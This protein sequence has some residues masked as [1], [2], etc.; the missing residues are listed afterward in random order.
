VLIINA[1]NNLDYHSRVVEVDAGKI[2]KILGLSGIEV[3]GVGP[4]ELGSEIV[5]GKEKWREI[6]ARSP[7]DF[8]S[9]NVPGYL[10]Y[11]RLKKERGLRVL[12]T[13]VVDPAML[14]KAGVDYPVK[15]VDPEV[16][17][18]QVLRRVK[19]DLAIVIIQ[20]SQERIAEI[21]N[22]CSGIDLVVDGMSRGV[23]NNFSGNKKPAS[24]L[25]P[26]VYNNS[27]GK[28]VVCLDLELADSGRWLCEKPQRR[29]AFTDSVKPDPEIEVL[30]SELRNERKTRYA[31]LREEKARKYMRDNP[32]DMYLGARGCQN[33]HLEIWQQWQQTR[34]AGAWRSLVRKQREEDGACQSCHVT[35]MEVPNTVGG[36]MSPD[37][38][39]W[40]TGVQCEAC[41]GPGGR[42]VT[43]PEANRMLPGDEKG[44]LRCHD[45]QNDPNF[46]YREKWLKIKHGDPVGREGAKR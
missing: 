45:Q 6:V 36:F 3:V 37:E 28:A 39:P 4:F 13:S 43:N 38:T 42:H 34:H 29:L 20:A 40:M 23:G 25:L 7:V 17:I 21:V 5:I 15:L 41:H 32:P 8:V 1:G 31:I 44:C 26:I 12:V 11:L 35:G 33:C 22:K 10:P 9:A 16:A 24:N 27:R 30:V 18:N 19:H 46:D 14:K 2:Y